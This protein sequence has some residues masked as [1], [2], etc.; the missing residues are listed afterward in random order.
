M[1]TLL[2]YQ[3]VPPAKAAVASWL[4]HVRGPVIAACR[5]ARVTGRR[6]ALA[7]ARSYGRACGAAPR[8]LVHSLGR[9]VA[10]PQPLG[11]PQHAPGCAR[12]QCDVSTARCAV[13]VRLRRP[14]AL[15]AAG[16]LQSARK[17]DASR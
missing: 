9:R 13:W 5:A 12:R 4:Q 6:S 10:T 2:A 1:S 3:V 11:L 14:A 15:R 8:R 7:G 17:C 16:V